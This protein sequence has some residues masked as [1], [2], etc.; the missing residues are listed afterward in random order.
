MKERTD[1]EKNVEIR[2]R[3][4]GFYAQFKV[5]LFSLEN[6]FFVQVL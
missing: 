2:S 4:L 6:L 1:C 3:F 5:G